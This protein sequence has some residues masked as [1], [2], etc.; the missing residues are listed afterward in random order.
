MC[1]LSSC[2]TLQFL[3]FLVFF[4]VQDRQDIRTD[5]G[6][7]LE[8]ESE[9]FSSSPQIDELLPSSPNDLP[10]NQTL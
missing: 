3:V 2:Q 5:A 8:A 4:F 1:I 7:N 10:H 9:E 6:V